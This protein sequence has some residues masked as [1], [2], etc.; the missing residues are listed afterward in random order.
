MSGGQTETYS[1]KVRGRAQRSRDLINA[2]YA[3]AE[4]ANPITGRGIGYKLFAAGLI[5]SMARSEMARVYR[6]LRE[7]REGARR[8]GAHHPCGLS[9]GDHFA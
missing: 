6:L 5:S 2:M 3:A 7:A 4:R 1:K 8:Y 9:F